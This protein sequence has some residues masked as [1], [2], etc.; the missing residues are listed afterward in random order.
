MSTEPLREKIAELRRLAKLSREN[1]EYASGNDYYESM[2]LYESRT[3]EADRLERILAEPK[4]KRKREIQHIQIL[5]RRLRMDDDTYRA[6]LWT[7]AR[8]KSTTEL[9]ELQRRKILDL[10]TAKQ[11]TERRWVSPRISLPP[12]KARMGKKICAI[13]GNNGLTHGYADSIAK[14]M[15]QVDRWEFLH[16]D[17]LHKLIAALE[18]QY[19]AHGR[20]RSKN[21]G[22]NS[23]HE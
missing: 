17:D 20:A 11:P 22:R 1:A 10:L 5:R 7:H 13:L 9:D 4:D 15:H 23:K 12:H 14:Q 21:E 6:M 16:A 8:V 3:Q 19:G 18:K 2:R